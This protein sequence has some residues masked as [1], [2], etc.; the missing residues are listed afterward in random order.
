[1][2]MNTKPRTQVQNGRPRGTTNSNVS[3]NGSVTGREVKQPQDD[4]VTCCPECD[5][6]IVQSGTAEKVC[7]ECGLVIEDGQIDPG[8]EWRG[9][10]STERNKKKRVGSPN[11]RLRHDEGL[12]TKIG[13]RNRDSY[14]N[15]ITGRKRQRLKRLRKWDTI[16]KASSAKERTL[17]HGLGEVSR[18]GTSLGISKQERETAAIIFRKA[19]EEEV[20]IGRSVEGVAS[21]ALYTAIRMQGIPRTLDDIAQVSRVG[22]KEISRARKDITGTLN[23]NVAPQTPVKHVARYVTNLVSI[24]ENGED[25]DKQAIERRVR[26]AV[27][28][29][30]EQG[31]MSGR[32]VGTV[33]GTC[34]WIDSRVNELEVNQ[35]EIAEACGVTQ[36]TVR[37]TSRKFSDVLGHSVEEIRAN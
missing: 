36:V 31:L 13:W 15:Q 19:R 17:Q 7:R 8:P 33:V 11:T 2:P 10:N 1:M 22:K 5:G 18:M 29:I 24:A 34:L 14:G 6:R 25:L 9:F 3:S 23:I 37:N 26:E 35:I 30:Q 21:A 32:K 28:T 20:L 4:E 27:R 12:T 16:A